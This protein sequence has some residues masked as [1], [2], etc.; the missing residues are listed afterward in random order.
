MV[1]RVKLIGS[2]TKE[3]ANRV[4]LPTYSLLHGNLTQG[5]ALVHV[6][7]DVHG[8]TAKDL[9]HEKAEKTTEGI[10]YPEL[11]DGCIEKLHKN[12]DKKYEEHK[13]EFRV[14]IAK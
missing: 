12:L 14:E 4:N 7:D 5:W 2:G 1:I 10:H 3:D 9:E 8:L 6:P 13:G 11:C